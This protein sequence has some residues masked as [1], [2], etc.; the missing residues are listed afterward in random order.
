MTT[1]IIGG[2]KKADIELLIAMAKKMGLNARLMSKQE[3]EDWA[4][5]QKIDAGMKSGRA[6]RASVMKA[7]DN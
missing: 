2:G 7:L 3:A 5:A 6:S 4:L 1:A